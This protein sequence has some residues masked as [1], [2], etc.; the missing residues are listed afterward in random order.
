MLF[1]AGQAAFAERVVQL[2]QQSG[3][4]TVVT[5]VTTN[6][7]LESAVASQTWDAVVTTADDRLPSPGAVA[8]MVTAAL[9][10]VPVLAVFEELSSQEVE[11]LLAAP[12]HDVVTL[13]NPYRLVLALARE[14]RGAEERRQRRAVER[15]LQESEE[16]FRRL[17][18]NAQDIIFR[19]RFRPERRSEFM[20]PA[21]ETITGY[22]PEEFYADPN[23]VER[24]V[25]PDDIAWARTLL[26]SGQAPSQMLYR[27]IRRDGGVIW[28][29]LR[30]TTLRDAEGNVEAIEGVLRDVTEREHG[31]QERRQRAARTAALDEVSRAL[32]AAS[33]DVRAI[34]GV[35]AEHT[36]EF[37]G[38]S[39]VIRLLS[40][41]RRRLDPVAFHHSDPVELDKMRLALE[42]IPIPADVGIHGSVI[43][44]GE[45]LLFT[46]AQPDVFRTAFVPELTAYLEGMDVHSLALV[47]IRLDGRPEGLLVVGRH[48]DRPP[49]SEED[50]V[51]LQELA[52][53]AGLALANAR[54]FDTVE[55]QLHRVE[56]LRNVG[57]AIT[58]SLDISVTLDVILD[59]VVHLL[60][61]DAA[62]VALLDRN[63][64]TLTQTAGR[65]VHPGGPARGRIRVGEG[66]A[67]RVAADRRTLVV[68]DLAAADP[69]PETRW[70][71]RGGFVSYAAAP[72]VAKG[73]V[74]GVLE[75]YHR[76]PL[77]PTEEWLDFLQALSNQAAIGLDNTLLFENLQRAHDD[78]T[79][80]YETT[81]EG[82][83]RAL[84]LRDHETE[85]HSQ[86]VTL[87]TVDLAHALG[88][89]D[90]EIVHVRRGALLHDIGKMGVPDSILLKP[91]PLTDEEW[92]VMR[93]HPDYARNFLNT[94]DYLR[95]AMDIPYC[96]HERFDGSGY[97]R[98]LKADSIPLVARA[99][100][101][102]DIADA[103][104]SN[105]PYRSG[106][107]EEQVHDHLRSLAG[108]HLDPE[109]VPVYI[110]LQG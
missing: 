99:F 52:D 3:L 82:W 1:A 102:V 2:L 109:L 70:L 60:R 85:G 105:R 15:A 98:G 81:L 89:S 7:E 73:Q 101:I 5:T 41:D 86:R 31:E 84:D 18:E 21:V 75:T 59:Q 50:R 4:N 69:G 74:L 6:S 88:L 44:S 25:H 71:R 65:G 67:G 43:A 93:R 23:F 96:H 36:A 100:A 95:P 62:A 49:Y 17:A 14:L 61:A 68:R 78:L 83:V 22:R 106:W 47:P 94:I 33:L 9:G 26:T 92:T 104:R 64:F 42:E 110:S 8:S 76:R 79:L 107:A 19:Y 12:V 38:E 16:R 53:R 77:E 108:T 29:D 28:M 80:A 32:A 91:G 45:A 37:I 34:L 30:V 24:V 11:A 90:T 56:G 97:P 10:D 35:L 51:F 13:R 63:T 48:Q 39:C 103:L 57:L 20:S 58:G 54:L 27:W 55:E 72:L 40:P 87:G 46:K 66:L